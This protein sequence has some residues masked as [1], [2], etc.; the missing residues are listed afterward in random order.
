MVVVELQVVV[1][2]LLLGK[3]MR[4]DLVLEPPTSAPAVEV[5]LPPPVQMEHQLLVDLVVLELHLLFLDH[6]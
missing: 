6:Q 2:H 3:V 1:Q 4:V 5:A